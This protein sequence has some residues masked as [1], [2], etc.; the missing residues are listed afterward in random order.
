MG[1]LAIN[2]RDK[3]RINLLA[4]LDRRGYRFVTPTPATHAIVLARDP[5]AQARDIRD[6]LG[7]C[8]PFCEASIDEELFSALR[9]AEM[10]EGPPHRLCATARVSSL[11]DQLVIHSAFPT[12][13]RD[14][15]FFGPDS[16]RFADL[17]VAEL[18]PLTR[19][20]AIIV[21]IGTGA[22]VGAIAT[23]TRRPS[24]RVIAT[25][26]N[27]SALAF[28]SVNAA[29]ASASID[30]R[31]GD[32]L[33]D[34]EGPIDLAV[35]NPPYIVDGEGRTYRDGGG[36]HGAALSLRMVAEVLPRLAPGGRFILYTGSA[37]VGGD[38]RF[39]HAAGKL[40]NAHDCQMRYREIDPDVFGEELLLPAYAE[41]ER[42]A[43]VAAIFI[44]PTRSD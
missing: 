16:Y 32:I 11:H 21:D 3:A 42:I 13:E 26:I 2:K 19:T 37:I 41:V 7:W 34:I 29:A 18:P 9:I 24:A 44:N 1:E 6:I 12:T 4:M 43:A 25:D 31:E 15:V 14:A 5:G 30:F 38:D 22:G 35:A 36:A 40:A 28:A 27:P 8:L 20:G 33:A 17:I 23:A 39:R 10:V